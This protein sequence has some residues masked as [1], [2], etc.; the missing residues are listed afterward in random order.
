M[1]LTDL[2]HSCLA[3][4]KPR[5]SCLSDPRLYATSAVYFHA[6]CVVYTFIGTNYNHF[7]AVAVAVADCRSRR[8]SIIRFWAKS[9]R[10]RP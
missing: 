4:A 7:V 8:P 1:T 6:T 5:K 2:W 10:L 9:I 3:S